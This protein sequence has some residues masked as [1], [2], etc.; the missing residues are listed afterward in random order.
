ME[1]VGG[2]LVRENFLG[3]FVES[4]SK[5]V[6]SFSNTIEAIWMA[7]RNNK[8]IQTKTVS[9]TRPIIFHNIYSIRRCTWVEVKVPSLAG[10]E[11]CCFCFGKG[12][13]SDQWFPRGSYFSRLVDFTQEKWAVSIPVIV[14][15]ATLLNFVFCL[16]EIAFWASRARGRWCR[17]K[18]WCQPHCSGIAA[19]WVYVHKSRLADRRTSTVQQKFWIRA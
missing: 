5:R 2:Q 3:W 13:I 14:F 10:D 7:S 16:P 1:D 15:M 6:K 17:S 19:G 12:M 8:E 18:Y 9:L 11:A 4:A